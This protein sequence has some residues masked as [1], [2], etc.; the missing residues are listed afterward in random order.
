MNCIPMYFGRPQYILEIISTSAWWTVEI[1]ER[2]L[3]SI[4]CIL[5]CW[6][7]LA[8]KVLGSVYQLSSHVFFFGTAHQSVKIEVGASR[9]HDSHRHVRRG[10]V[11]LV[12]K[13][14]M[15]QTMA[16]TKKCWFAKHG[17]ND[18]KNQIKIP[19]KIFFSSWWF[20]PHLKTKIVKIG[21]FSK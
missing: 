13:Y 19:R 14:Q 9:F 3:S 17:R 8:A 10:F 6:W 5:S 21:I 12:G 20:Q 11:F 7:S 16:S 2:I 15:K 1:H 18:P 4:M